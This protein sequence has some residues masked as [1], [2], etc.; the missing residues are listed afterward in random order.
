MLV[1]E[2]VMKCRVDT[3]LQTGRRQR[4]ADDNREKL[5]NKDMKELLVKRHVTF[6]GVGENITSLTVEGRQTT[7]GTNYFLFIPTDVNC[8]AC[9]ILIES[10]CGENKVHFIQSQCPNF[11]KRFEV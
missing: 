4:E 1:C 8:H 9:V 11:P 3:S 10:R 6:G 2:A 5:Q 7:P